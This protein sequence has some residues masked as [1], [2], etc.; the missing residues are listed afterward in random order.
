MDAL[1]VLGLDADDT[2]WENGIGFAAVTSR[3]CDLVS[4]WVDEPVAKAALIETERAHVKDHG[5]GVKGFILSII[6]T[7]IALSEGKVTGSQIAPVLDWG[8]ELIEAPIDLLPGVTETISTL[9]ADHRLLLI[10]KGDPIEQHRKVD[11]SGL[12]D[13]LW[14]VE[15]VAEK[16]PETY[17][18]VL[19]R[20]G[21]EPTGFVMVGN[22]LP[23]DVLPVLAIGGRAVHIPH[24]ITWALETVEDEELEHHEFTVLDSF[25]ELPALLAAWRDQG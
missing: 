17:T 21:V 8:R 22:S 4:P 3:Y 13:W 11:G 25:T 6:E 18:D 24:A 16:N 2:L 5:Y 10:T 19:R 20:H 14:G 9:A 12:A 23:S 7:V 15:V 1:P